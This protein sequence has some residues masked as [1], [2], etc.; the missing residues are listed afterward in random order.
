MTEETKDEDLKLN[1]QA[2][3]SVT[4]GEEPPKDG[5]EDEGDE[6]IA[7]SEDDGD[8][9]GH[10]EESDEDKAERAERNRQRRLE[11]KQRKKEYVESLKRELSARDRI[12]NEMNQR[13]ATI[14]R[15]STGSEMAQLE[16]AEREAANMY[17]HFKNI[18]QQAIE[19]ANGAAATEAQE[20]MF[21]AR[22]RFEQLQN[23]KRAMQSRQK[24]PQPLDPRLVNHAQQWMESNKR[25]DPTGNDDHS[26]IA[27]TIDAR[28]AKEGCDPT[29]PE[30]WDELETRI[31]RKLPHLAKSGYTN[32]QVG[33]RAPPVAGSGRESS[34]GSTSTYKLSAERVQALKESG[35]WDDPK[36]RAEAVKRFQQ[37]DRENRQ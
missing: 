22:Q 29:T 7:K 35:L 4:V 21:Q 24:A 34:G 1:E 32:S 17:N 18:N 16:Q 10:P 13:L 9:E 20:R 5:A 15:K 23:I 19:Q 31:K 11:S 3:G 36:Q 8:E 28:M 14:E 37:Y 33:R 27:L 6:R 25:Y 2:D 12:I 26:A 30:Y